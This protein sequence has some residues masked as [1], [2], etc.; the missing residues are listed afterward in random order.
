RLLSGGRVWH[1]R[2]SNMVDAA[3]GV[4]RSTRQGNAA[5]RASDVLNGLPSAG[6]DAGPAAAGLSTHTHEAGLLDRIAG[7]VDAD[8]R[9]VISDAELDPGSVRAHL[10]TANMNTDRKTRE[11]AQK[12]AELR[13]KR[14]WT[15]RHYR[16]RKWIGARRAALARAFNAARAVGQ[17]ATSPR[18]KAHAAHVARTGLKT[19]ATAVL[20][21]NPLTAGYGLI[22]ATK[23]AAERKNWRSLGDVL[24]VLETGGRY[25]WNTAA[26]V[27]PEETVDVRSMGMRAAFQKSLD[28]ADAGETRPLDMAAGM[29]AAGRENPAQTAALAQVNREETVA[30]PAAQSSGQETPI[31]TTPVQTVPAQ[32]APAQSGGQETTATP[33]PGANA[34]RPAA[35][36][37]HVFRDPR[38]DQVLALR[39]RQQTITDQQAAKDAHYLE[40][41]RQRK[42]QEEAVHLATQHQDRA[43]NLAAKR[44]ANAEFNV[45]Y[46]LNQ[47][48]GSNQV[49]NARLR[50]IARERGWGKMEMDYAENRL[51]RRIFLRPAQPAAGTPGQSE[52][53]AAP[54][55][56]TS[57]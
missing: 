17:G 51:G 37:N 43:E 28:A 24:G 11:H 27:T 52:T 21:A 19:A 31:Q 10:A 13:E 44:Q 3:T 16:V 7:N 12:L 42:V 18:F 35:K 32:P 56:G 1:G 46:A 45:N 36:R 50:T 25:V 54:A 47:L 4:G 15:E 55:D 33:T 39:A 48:Q 30:V 9:Q 22:T 23:M 26:V 29:P 20:L 57:Q 5:S 2:L 6:V 34:A 40:V 14:G 49:I 8:G 53:P 38:V 41:N